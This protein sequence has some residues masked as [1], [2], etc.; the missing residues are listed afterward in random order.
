MFWHMSGYIQIWVIEQLDHPLLYQQPA[1]FLSGIALPYVNHNSCNIVLW[2]RLLWSAPARQR[3]GAY[4]PAVS[5]LVA[6]HCSLT[7][8][9]WELTSVFALNIVIGK[10][11]SPAR[12]NKTTKVWLWFHTFSCNKFTVSCCDLGVAF[13]YRPHHVHVDKRKPYFQWLT[14][15]ETRHFLH[16]GRRP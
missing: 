12:E 13:Q 1:K 6:G 9:K 15:Y 16:C 11:T 5:R 3:H 14:N 8:C 7:G 10:C 4:Q 2:N